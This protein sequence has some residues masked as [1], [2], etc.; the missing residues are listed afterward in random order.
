MIRPDERNAVA[1]DVAHHG[2]TAEDAFHDRGR[3]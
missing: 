3:K 1:E 2:F